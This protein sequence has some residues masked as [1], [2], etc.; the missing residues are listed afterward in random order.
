MRRTLTTQTRSQKSLSLK[1]IKILKMMMLNLE[2]AHKMG[3]KKIIQMGV[4]VTATKH[5]K[6]MSNQRSPRPLN[7]LTN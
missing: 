4:T 3:T 2:M 1:K 6:M 5:Q 7:A